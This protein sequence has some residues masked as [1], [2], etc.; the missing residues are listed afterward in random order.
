MLEKLARRLA[1]GGGTINGLSTLG[2]P[3]KW[4]APGSS[5]LKPGDVLVIRAM[6]AVDVLQQVLVA[7]ANG[8]VPFVTAADF[9][10]EVWWRPRGGGSFSVPDAMAAWNLPASCAVIHA[11]SGSTGLPRLV[12]RSGESLL[13]EADCYGGAFEP[14]GPEPLCALLPVSH[15][16]GWGVTLS[17]LLAGR[18]VSSYH[19][20]RLGELIR[21]WSAWSVLATT[22]TLL[23]LLLEVGRDRELERPKAVFCGAGHMRSEDL[24]MAKA[25][26]PATEFMY[27]FGST[28]T[29]GVACGTCGI[30]R[31]NSGIRVLGGSE[32]PFALSVEMPH[33]VLGYVDAPHGG[34]RWD[35]DDVVRWRN[36]HLEHMHRVSQVPRASEAKVSLGELTEILNSTGRDWRLIQSAAQSREHFTLV[37]EGVTPLEAG[38]EARVLDLLRERFSADLRYCESFPRN[39]IGKVDHTALAGLVDQVAEGTHL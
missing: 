25:A 18:D 7:W 36:D 12:M 19:P 37:V 2:V 30:G 11:T 34:T 5:Q 21:H 29:G 28:E 6:D 32:D 10:Q 4:T 20:Q 13:W 31:P 1:S 33:V 27:G 9:P 14:Y 26:W 38:V 3:P 24:I 35:F 8:A 22:P 39:Y 23:R 15:S 17:A 16:L